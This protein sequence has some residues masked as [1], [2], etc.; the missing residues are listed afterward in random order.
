MKPEEITDEVREVLKMCNITEERWLQFIK[1]ITSGM[2]EYADEGIY[3][4]EQR[5]VQ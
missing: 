4:E 3:R 2:E 1:T 5:D